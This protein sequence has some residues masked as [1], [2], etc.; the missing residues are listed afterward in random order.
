MTA[1]L[2]DDTPFDKASHH[3]ADALMNDKLSQD[4][5]WQRNQKPYVRLD[6]AK[7]GE[8]CSTQKVRLRQGQECQWHP[9]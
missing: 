8:L 1:Y 2:G 9:A 4:Q 5:D 7:E 3:W 6:I